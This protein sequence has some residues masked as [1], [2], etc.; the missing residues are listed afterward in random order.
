MKHLVLCLLA[1]VA[2]AAL[3]SRAAQPLDTWTARNPLP[4]GNSLYSIT[5]GI[6]IAGNTNFVAVGQ[7]GTIM[8]ATTGSNW[9]TRVSGTNCDLLGVTCGTNSFNDPQ[10][11]AVGTHSATGRGNILVSVDGIHWSSVD[12][13][14]TNSLNAVT[15]GQDNGGVPLFVA[16]GGLGTIIVSG[17]GTNWSA[18]T[19][20]TTNVLYGVAYGDVSDVRTFVAVGLHI[21]ADSTSSGTFITS[22]DGGATW[23]VNSV[24]PPNVIFKCVTYVSGAGFVAAGTSGGIYTSKDGLTWKPRSSGTADQLNG[25]AFGDG[26]LMAVGQLGTARTSPDSKAWST[27]NTGVTVHLN[28]VAYGNNTFVVVGDTGLTLT[29]ATGSTWGIGRFRV[30]TSSFTGVAYGN[31]NY[32]AVGGV[33]G[34]SGT[35][36]TSSNGTYWT[37]LGAWTNTALF[38]VTFGTNSLGQPLFVA[39]GNPLTNNVTPAILISGD[40]INWSTLYPGG[41]GG[42]LSGVTCGRDQSGPLFVVVS[43]LADVLTSADGTNW[44]THATSQGRMNAVTYGKGRFV[45]VGSG[46]SEVSTD[47]INWTAGTGVSAGLLAGV[48]YG[49]GVFVAVGSGS[50]GQIYTSPDGTNWTANTSGSSAGVLNG[51]AFGRGTFVVVGQLQGPSGETAGLFTSTDGTNWVARDCGAWGNLVGVTYGSGEVSQFVAVGTQDLILGATLSVTT[52]IS[53]SPLTGAQLP[54]MDLPFGRI[55]SVQFSSD[56]ANWSPLTNFFLSRNAPGLMVSDPSATNRSRGFYSIGL[57]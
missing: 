31:N 35:V 38:A 14:T 25:L 52:P 46:V 17:D 57:R 2:T 36:V 5:Y 50:G 33:Q 45:A 48:A 10:L 18:R 21:N 1:N 27:E 3:I 49:K 30:V 54:I 34:S 29:T 6:S 13:G 28:A 15:Y 16:V 56:L 19:S 32:V 26:E 44:T 24:F 39:T 43:S 9:I 11:V 22:T 55:I 51:I 41:T 7:A 37:H 12:A 53:Y 8:T 42:L 4:T 40:A 20:G 47:A 23:V